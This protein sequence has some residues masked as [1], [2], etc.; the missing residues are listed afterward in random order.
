[1]A[2]PLFWI[3]VS[4]QIL[5]QENKYLSSKHC[6]ED[7]GIDSPQYSGAYNLFIYLSFHPF[8]KRLVS[9]SYLY[10]T[11]FDTEM[12]KNKTIVVAFRELCGE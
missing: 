5:L 7:P 12:N 8:S 11:L 1:M 10:H 6:M 3:Y 2:H 4:T 9:T